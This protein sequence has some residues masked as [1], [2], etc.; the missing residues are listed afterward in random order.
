M[1]E[2]EGECDAM[3]DEEEPVEGLERDVKS[4]VLDA[5]SSSVD[6]FIGSR[7]FTNNA[8]TYAFAFRKVTIHLNAA[9]FGPGV[10]D[11]SS[12]VSS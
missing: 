12:F 6:S 5:I 4:A 1:K 2:G 10:D 3:G 8:S 9:Y 7:I 11:C